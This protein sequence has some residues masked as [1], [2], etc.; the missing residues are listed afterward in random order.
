MA[1]N[2]PWIHKKDDGSFVNVPCGWC[3]QCRIDKRNE[4]TLRLSFEV[5]QNKGSFIT[6]TYDDNHLPKDE[7]LH[8][9]DVQKF[10]KRLRKNI[11][12]KFKIKYY[13][14]GEY[15]EKGNIVTGLQRPHYH[16]IVTGCNALK[17]QTYISKSW[18]KGFIKC[19]PA[20]VGTIRYTLKYMDKQ[21][22]GIE[23]IKKEYGEK[24]PPFALM[25][26]GIGLNYLKENPEIIEHYQGIPFQGHVRPIPRYYKNYFDVE[27]PIRKDTDK[28]RK[29]IETMKKLN[30]TENQAL[31]Y[32]GNI[33]EENLIAEINLYNKK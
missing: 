10:I 26:Q 6:L 33:N 21:I 5:Q 20:D 30:M 8:K 1:C 32:L 31:N 16:L 4:W 9:E 7:S 22:H 23:N 17:M 18:N 25:S 28:K 11:N 15:G 27:N 14:V 29:V 13:A 2:R 3:I 24:Q 19:L 12:N